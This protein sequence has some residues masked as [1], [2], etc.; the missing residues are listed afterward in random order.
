MVHKYCGTMFCA[1]LPDSFSRIIAI[2]NSQIN[3]F[4]FTCT[5]QEATHVSEVYRSLPNCGPSVWKLLH[6]TLLMPVI[7]SRLLDFWE[8]HGT[9][10]EDF[11][12]SHCVFPCPCD[13]SSS[14]FLQCCL[15]LDHFWSLFIDVH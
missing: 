6:L 1:L 11:F 14:P 4:Y 12:L 5:K 13:G 15:F 3:A 8:S 2:F 7:W 9:C 10:L